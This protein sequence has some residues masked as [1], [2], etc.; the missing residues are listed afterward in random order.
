MKLSVRIVLFG[1][2]SLVMITQFQNCSSTSE[3]TLFQSSNVDTA[4]PASSDPAK[5]F[6]QVSTLVS[7]LKAESYENQISISGS[8]NP[9]GRKY[10]YIQYSVIESVSRRILNLSTD[11]N[12]VKRELRDARC[13]NG[14][15]YMVVPLVTSDQEGPDPAISSYLLSVEFYV[16]DSETSWEPKVTSSM[17]LLIN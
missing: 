3:N 7:P 5:P 4:S 6:I 9:G 16:S 13:E 11:S 14:K 17:A 2:F 1:F 15:F 10:N 12:V 8:C